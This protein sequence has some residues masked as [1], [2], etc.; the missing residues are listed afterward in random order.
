VSL[1]DRVL[2]TGGGG[3]LAYALIRALRIPGVEPIVLGRADLDISNAKLVKEVIGRHEPT[4]ILNCAAY[5][6]VDLCES[7]VDLAT[8]VNAGG[9]HAIADAA[10]MVRAKL[11]HYSTDFVFDGQKGTPYRPDDAVNPLSMYGKSKRAGEV[12]IRANPLLDHLIIRTAWLYGPNGPCF[13]QT[14]I[15]AAKAGK[16]LK[17]V[18][19]QKGTPTFTFDLAEA[20]LDLLDHNAK[21]IWHLTNSGETTWFDFTAA[22]LEEFNLE[23]DLSPT[24]SAE[25]KK[26]KPSSAIRPAYSVLD[27]SPYE[28]LVGKSMPHWRDALH[29]YHLALGQI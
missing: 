5:T 13:P 18:N 12:F 22:I 9:A 17:V 14:M 10:W 24:T 19:D 16:P 3:M 25:W 28:K 26:L 23:T 27:V 7:E 1:Y 2:I 4:L 8:N 20:T 11:V 6:K 15:N 29:R 21:G